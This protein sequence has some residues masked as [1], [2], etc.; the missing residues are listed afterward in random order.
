VNHI[1]EQ[2]YNSAPVLVQNL[3][4]SLYGLAWRRERLG[5]DFGKHVAGFSERDRWSPDRMQEYLGAELRKR[6]FHAFE[7]VPY[8]NEKWTKVG[9]THNDILRVR[10]ADLQQLPV[11]PKGDFRSSPDSFVA[12]D[13]ARKHR[14]HRYYSSGSTGTPVT[15]ICTSDGHRRFIAAREVRSFGWAGTS[16]RKPRAMIG[17]RMVVPHSV[18]PPPYYRYNL[19][20]RQVYFSAYHLAPAHVANYVEGFNK[21]RPCVFT[22]YAYSY[23]ILARMM[24]DQGLSLNYKPEA[25]VLCSEKL[26]P[27]MKS[28]LQRVFQARAYED[29]GA[30]ENCC[31]ATE[32]EH[33]SLHV[34]PDFGII[35][36]V[37]ANGR[38]VLPGK[39]G[40]ILCTGLQNFAQ[41]LI[42][43]EIGDVGI[44]STG[45][46]PCGRNHLPV[47]QEVVGRLEDVVIGADGREM[48][49]FHG[50]FIDLPHVLE[51]QVVQEAID[52]FRVRVVTSEGFGDVDRKLIQ[53]RF[54]DRLGQ[55]QVQIEQVEELKRTERGKFRAV[56]SNLSP[57]QRKVAQRL[58]NKH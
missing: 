49:R 38:S 31:L 47:L 10:L 52:R 35:E 56:I 9:L 5:G 19:A 15:H 51:G 34:S 41:P 12:R 58:D 26:T 39:E 17:G 54:V 14:L 42:R 23:Y 18:A 3:G 11:T 30:V 37:D 1:L 27:D 8:Y 50:I 28:V 40:R 53:Q 32:C 24:L 46:C 57:V 16:I 29:Y 43:Y 13:V 2:F 45:G 55:V 20:E 33:G 6:L 21:Y 36:V 4:I 22:G 44:L 25:L 7:Q 48:V